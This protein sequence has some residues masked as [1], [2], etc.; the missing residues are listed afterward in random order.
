MNNCMRS[1]SRDSGKKKKERFS[2]IPRRTKRT[3]LE[4]RYCG[5]NSVLGSMVMKPTCMSPSRHAKEA[6]DHGWPR[7]TRTCP[8]SDST[9]FSRRSSTNSPLPCLPSSCSFSNSFSGRHSP[10]PA[11]SSSHPHSR[12]W[13][14][15]AAAAHRDARR[16]S[17]KS[18]GAITATRRPI[19][20][21]A[22]PP[23]L[24]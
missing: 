4:S 5:T 1:T 15:A 8:P 10:S 7:T 19:S 21:L 11:S 6:G 23:K 14:G 24:C 16:S 22:S 20:S 9:T 2:D 13:R 3:M 18:S 12:S 17:E